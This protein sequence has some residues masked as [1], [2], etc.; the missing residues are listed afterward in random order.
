MVQIKNGPYAAADNFTMNRDYKIEYIVVH[1]TANDGDTDEGNAIYFRDG[2]RGV[3][4]HYFVDEDSITQTVK[5]EHIAW[6]CGTKGTYYNAYCRNYNSIGVEMCSDKD[7]HG[8]YII[9]KQT[10]KNTVDLVKMLMKKYNIPIQHIL[11]HYDVTHKWCPKPWVCDPSLWDNFKLKL[12]EEEM[13]QEEFVKMYNEMIAMKHGDEPSIWAKDACE[14]AQKAGV[15]NG[16]GNGNYD[17]Q[18]PITREAVAV[19]LSNIGLI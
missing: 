1:Y 10:V 7:I 17:W 8:E 11:R 15:F 16:D 9:T 5:D 4:A 6:H 19:I 2:V 3:S 14:K 18:E 12:E 13:T